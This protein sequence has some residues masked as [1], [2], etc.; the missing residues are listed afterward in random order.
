MQ[1]SKTARIEK[2]ASSNATRLNMNYVQLAEGIDGKLALIATNGHALAICPVDD[3]ENDDPGP[4]TAD[5][6]KAARK[7]GTRKQPLIIKTNG[8][9]QFDNGL[10]MEKPD[11]RD[12]GEFPNWKR[13]IPGDVP[14]R[15]IGINPSLLMDLAHAI[16]SP[17]GVILELG[18]DGMNAIKVKPAENDNENVGVIMPM[19]V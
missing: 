2:V 3:A 12:V 5:A 16:D 1:I 11:P 17:H 7:V 10:T 18:Q 15:V 19:R 6:I 4:I 14:E 13:V 9:Y 8:C